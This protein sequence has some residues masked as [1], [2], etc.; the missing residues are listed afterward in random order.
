MVDARKV[1][2]DRNFDFFQRNLGLYLKDHAGEFALL[3][4]ARLVEFFKGPGDAY[5]AGL[6][7]FSDRMFS[8]QE[9]R[10]EPIHLGNMSL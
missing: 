4:N 2:I 8:V 6:A 9:V 7:R 5:R 10:R 1:E 3:K